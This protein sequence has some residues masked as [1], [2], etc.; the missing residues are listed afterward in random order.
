MSKD[1]LLWG[2]LPTIIAICAG[3]IS[4]FA[5]FKSQRISQIV[6][7]A[8]VVPSFAWTLLML[9]RMFVLSAWPSYLPHLLI[10]VALVIVTA[11]VIMFWRNRNDWPDPY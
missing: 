2:L 11:Q 10:F 9:Y 8:V 6:A 1:A 5:A 3:L 4:L 7:S